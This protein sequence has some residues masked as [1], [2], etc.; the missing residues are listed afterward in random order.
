[1]SMT[2][3]QALARI[4]ELTGVPLPRLLVLARVLREAGLWPQ[5]RKGGGIGAARVEPSHYAALLLAL[6]RDVVMAGARAVE[7]IGSL[8]VN[9]TV[10][11]VADN[12]WPTSFADVLPKLAGHDFLTGLACVIDALAEG[13][14]QDRAIA[15]NGHSLMVNLYQSETLEYQAGIQFLYANGAA[16]HIATYGGNWGAP[17]APTQKSIKPASVVQ[18]TYINFDFLVMLADCWRDARVRRAAGNSSSAPSSSEPSEAAADVEG[19]G[20]PHPKPSK[21]SRSREE[22]DPPATRQNLLASGSDGMSRRSRESRAARV[23]PATSL[24]RGSMKSIAVGSP[25]LASI[26]ST[27]DLNAEIRALGGDPPN[28]STVRGH[29]YSGAFNLYRLPNGKLG[30]LR[31]DLPAIAAQYGAPAGNV[32]IAA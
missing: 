11:S 18:T 17:E 13:T 28:T 9:P 30:V 10:A 6:S 23:Q 31:A 4:A 1:M 24:R 7:E 26:V 8:P 16:S 20:L 25:L 3:S 32:E 5:S 29:G 27:V 14:A 12:R 22:V 15:W 2:S 19:S 21:S